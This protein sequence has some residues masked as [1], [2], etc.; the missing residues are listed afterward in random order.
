MDTV[1]VTAVGDMV[2]SSNHETFI[3]AAELA[4]AKNPNLFALIIGRPVN[5]AGYEY[6]DNLEAI[7]RKLGILGTLSFMEFVEDIGPLIAASNVVVTL[8]DN[9]PF[10]NS[11][12]H[13]VAHQKRLVIVGKSGPEEI[14]RDYE[15]AKKARLDPQ[16]IADVI[17]TS[18]EAGP[19][20]PSDPQQNKSIVER[21]T[22]DRQVKAIDRFIAERINA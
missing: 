19:F 3:R 5:S 18:I 14:A 10:S 13:A 11:A 8:S 21:F 22:V 16:N 12:V 2:P 17:T 15:A 1:F 9:E 7:A 6:V 20:K 4:Y